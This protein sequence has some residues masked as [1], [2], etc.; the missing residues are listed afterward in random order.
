MPSKI[1]PIE[2]G[3]ELES[4]IVKEINELPYPWA[5]SKMN[6]RIEMLNFAHTEVSNNLKDEVHERCDDFIRG[7]SANKEVDEGV[8]RILL[9]MEEAK[10]QIVNINSNIVQNG[11]KIAQ[12]QIRRQ[13]YA[14]ITTI[15]S[16]LQYLYA[17]RRIATYLISNGEHNASA[18]ILTDILITAKSKETLSQLDSVKEL[19]A[20]V[21]EDLAEVRN[22]LKLRLESCLCGERMDSASLLDCMRAFAALPAHDPLATDLTRVI[23]EGSQM[24]MRE[25]LQLMCR[26]AFQ[27]QQK[28]NSKAPPPPPT[29]WSRAGLRELCRRLPSTKLLEAVRICCA[30]VWSGLSRFQL[31]LGWM[32]MVRTEIG[33][34]ALMNGGIQDGNSSLSSTSINRQVFAACNTSYEVVLALFSSID[35]PSGTN[36]TRDDLKVDL[37]RAIS[38]LSRLRGDSSPNSVAASNHCQRELDVF[39][40]RTRQDLLSRSRSY[41]WGRLLQSLTLIVSLIVSRVHATSSS[42]SSWREEDICSM[43]STLQCLVDE[44]DAF[45]KICP[46]V[47]R[48]FTPPSKMMEALSAPLP[49]LQQPDGSLIP[50]ALD[51]TETMTMQPPSLD[52]HPPFMSPHSINFCATIQANTMEWTRNKQGE[53]RKL[54]AQ[55]L[56]MET[57]DRL[58]IPKDFSSINALT[59]RQMVGP[60]IANRSKFFAGTASMS[61][62]G[63][64]LG[65]RFKVRGRLELLVMAVVR[66]EECFNVRNPF[67]LIPSENNDSTLLKGSKNSQLGLSNQTSLSAN[68]FMP[69]GFAA[70]LLGET[71][72]DIESGLKETLRDNR[73]ALTPTPAPSW[74]VAP[75]IPA[76]LSNG[77][78]S[79]PTSKED[80]APSAENQKQEQIIRE[81]WIRRLA[82]TSETM[83]IPCVTSSSLHVA[84]CMERLMAIA[85]VMPSLAFEVFMLGCRLIDHAILSVVAT[86]AGHQAFIDLTDRVGGTQNT[87]STQNRR[88][89]FNN[90]GQSSTS[91]D[92]EFIK[93]KL[94][95]AFI[96]KRFPKLRE[97]ILAIIDTLLL[98]L[99]AKQLPSPDGAPPPS[100]S[101]WSVVPSP[102]S[103]LGKHEELSG[104]AD[105]LVA[106]AAAEDLI[107]SWE[108]R[109]DLLVRSLD[110]KMLYES[111]QSSSGAAIDS[112]VLTTSIKTY[113]SHQKEVLSELRT[114]TSFYCA[115]DF[116]KVF[117][118]VS[119]AIFQV[120][121]S[122]MDSNEI[123][124]REPV[125][126]ALIELDRYL[127][128]LDLRM[129]TL[130]GGVLPARCRVAFWESLS[131]RIMLQLLDVIAV[132]PLGNENDEAKTHASLFAL[133]SVS[134]QIQMIV[135][136][137][138]KF[139]HPGTVAADA[140][141]PVASKLLV[142]TGGTSFPEIEL[143]MTIEGAELV[144]SFLE[145]HFFGVDQSI[146]WAKSRLKEYP[147]KV[148]IE[149]VMKSAK[150]Q[151][152]SIERI[153]NLKSEFEF[154]AKKLVMSSSGAVEGGGN[155]GTPPAANPMTGQF[156]GYRQMGSR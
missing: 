21:S 65:A 4:L 156:N 146:Q 150:K 37:Q 41:L 42:S 12:M 123:Q 30:E 18:L 33:R 100:L 120:R 104:A 34:M 143:E 87:V 3:T 103:K 15:L 151:K 10:L 20:H 81:D 102:F 113:F 138:I 13:R 77:A 115:K 73:A 142:P 155:G 107:A 46:H 137:R 145:A 72:L 91:S 62:A 119:A 147:F 118:P 148:L 70:L 106:C 154:Y 51:M 135:A 75:V 78:N 95:A 130:G 63:G 57:G 112:A 76:G 129:R 152:F 116:K 128:D 92:S 127:R 97:C 28:E 47:V 27:E 54:V 122:D 1:D 32:G 49:P 105:R 55:V 43:L 149:L 19:V 136:R 84:Q 134:R 36:G 64:K 40:S 93:K 6:S 71:S 58:P 139:G 82:E 16:D 124:K 108:Q 11:L 48:K 114:F 88:N 52:L 7:I 14:D 25:V 50:A 39:L 121:W 101:V 60:R 117:D 99:Q 53:V 85:V 96:S 83:N 8:S 79:A 23:A 24:K 68:S 17:L 38:Y 66:G 132:L 67:I 141:K 109:I 59:I 29:D 131:F 2:K 69:A 44:G 94:N 5:L 110:L 153:Q 111:G 31:M 98:D 80:P 140:L 86:M 125:G 26:S 144:S 90:N 61:S 35:N 133:A 74:L 126:K 56:E 22:A 45:H 89:N 9:E